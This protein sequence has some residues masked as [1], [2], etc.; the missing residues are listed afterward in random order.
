MGSDSAIIPANAIT[1][2]QWAARYGCGETKA[3]ND[4][5]KLVASGKMKKTFIYAVFYVPTGKMDSC[6]T[7][8][9]S[10]RTKKT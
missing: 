5:N 7:A 8:Q 1:A 9:K 3:R 4:L 10:K 2:G 6:P